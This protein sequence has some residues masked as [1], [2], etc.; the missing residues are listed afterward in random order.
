MH[1]RS[2]LRLREKITYFLEVTPKHSVRLS[3]P[4]P[5]AVAPSLR[6]GW[7]RWLGKIGLRSAAPR[8]P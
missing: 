2:P 1:L 5:E 4:V 7:Q 8:D 6:A 3:S